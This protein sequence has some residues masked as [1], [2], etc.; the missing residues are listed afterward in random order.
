MRSTLHAETEDLVV[1]NGID[2]STGLYL[3]PPVN[4]S[5]L[6]ELCSKRL[7]SELAKLQRPNDLSGS[8]HAKTLGL[9]HG[10][11]KHDVSQAGWGIVYPSD[12][13]PEIRDA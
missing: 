2:G 3:T 10:I 13:S 6:V 12:I 7:E 5:Q 8:V 11:Q 4:Q 9:P 1:F